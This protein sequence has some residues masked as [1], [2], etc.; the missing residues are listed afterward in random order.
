MG[1]A[2]EFTD[3]NFKTE[4]LDS[5]V[6]VVVDFSAT[7]CGPC[8][9]LAPVIDE[10]AKEYAGSVKIG[11]VDTEH[12]P[13]SASTYD[14]ASIPTVLF[15]RGGKRVDSVVGLQPKSVYKSKIDALKG[16]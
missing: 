2:L 14:I 15:F 5:K 7:W 11:K 13:E 9:Q 16:K 6:P 12:S 3:A 1:N 8:Q 10:L 4:V